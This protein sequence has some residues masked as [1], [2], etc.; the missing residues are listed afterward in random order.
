MALRLR[1]ALG[2]VSM[3]KTDRAKGV[4]SEDHSVSE[5]G[6][7]GGS[8][9]GGSS[10]Y[11]SEF[12]EGHGVDTECHPEVCTKEQVAVSRSRRTGR[13]TALRTSVCL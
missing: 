6:G 9:F 7:G 11:I 5:C 13:E 10:P 1:A 12:G 8:S 4:L 2:P 3:Y